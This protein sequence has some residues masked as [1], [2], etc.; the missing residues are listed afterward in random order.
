MSP[1]KKQLPIIDLK[2]L[3]Q[4]PVAVALFD[5]HKIYF[6]NKKALELFRIPKSKLKDIG[7][8]NVFRFLNPGTHKQ[9]F[10]NN[11]KVLKGH[12]FPGIELSLKDYKG[13]DRY[14]EINSN[15]TVHNGKKVIQSIFTEISERK[16][17]EELLNEIKQKFEL[18]TNNANDI[19][20]FYTYF[21]EERYIYVSPNI[22][23]ILGYNPE[24]LLKDKNFFNKRVSDNKRSFLGIDKDIKGLQ[25]KNSL[26]NYSYVFKT[27]KKNNEE[28]WLENSL[29][30]IT[31]PSGKVIFYVNVL[32]DITEHKQKEIE[33]QQ[34]KADYQTLLDNSQVAYA[35]HH[36]GTIV[37]SNKELLKLLK[38]KDKKDILGRFAADFFHVDERKRAIK[39]IKDI[40]LRKKINQAINYKLVDSKGNTIE[41]EIKSNLIKY[42]NQLSILSSIYNISQQRQ[43][44]REMLRAEISEQNNK[45]LQKEILEKQKVEKRLIEKTGQ[46]TSILESS[47]H[48]IWTVNRNN[49]ILSFNKNFYD[50]LFAKYKIKI[51]AG[52]K[53]DELIKKGKE[54]YIN[55][56]Y[57]KY[58]EAF[59]GHKL[60]F[61]RQEEADGKKI[62]RKIFI[63]PIYTAANEVLEVSCIAHDITDA[64]IY[65]QK[66]FNQAAKLNS[67]FDSSHHYIWTID[68][69]EK[70]T[71]FN[72][73]YFDLISNL[74]N[75]QPYIGLVLNRGV[76]SNNKEYNELL[77]FNYEK[78]FEGDSVNFE[79][80]TVDKEF[81]KIY[82]DIFLNPIAENNKVI[83]VSGIAHDVTEKKI[84]QQR[85]EQSL[86]EKEV[87]LKEVHHRVKN[88]MQ[89]ISS[90]LNLQSSYVSDDYALS[91]LKESQ[92]RIK[93]MA[94]IH[95]S[96]YQNKSFT[97]VNFS[98]YI[99]TLSNNIIQS[100]SVSEEKVRLV[101]NLEKIN[102]NLDSSIPTGL[103]VNELITNAIKHAFPSN[104]KGFIYVNLKSENNTVYLEVKDNGI[105]FDSNIDFRNS[106]S[107]GLQ[108]VSTL[109]DQ[110]E[111]DLKFKSEKDKG[112]EVL[113]TFKM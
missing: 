111:G 64:K 100:Y 95:E 98:D 85:M 78:A 79:I 31:N 27:L 45:L 89:V 23:K 34:Q 29:V 106:N 14:L 33:L 77:K 54:E 13:K 32:R 50:V 87:L 71:S 15:L 28:V 108:L 30:P 76:L 58:K 41:V 42:N 97:S 62:Y 24:E 83:E 2:T 44:E 88:N 38:L 65:E 105:G 52:D 8:L 112:T 39:R 113:I 55:I 102:L 74:Y 57:V 93:T 36:Q 4:L 49:E 47:S 68:R 59:K 107:L 35:I 51:K 10:T 70:L 19:I 7:D 43:L 25:K 11:S 67:I 6:I 81:N 75:T 82:L 20:C 103:I 18:I 110:I 9:I 86:K 104:A 37:F 109:I 60:E 94:Y 17:T 63:N 48:L 90:I 72:K 26:K 56:W 40:Y 84:A 61:E 53:I 96:L 46:L 16:K 91:L 80:E 12:K 66:L 21:P 5:N 92:N 99:A 101:L 73:N 69:N 22:K 3:D 1:T